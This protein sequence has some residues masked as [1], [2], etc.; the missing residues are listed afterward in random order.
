M[1]EEKLTSEEVLKRLDL[2]LEQEGNL[3]VFDNVKAEVGAR[4]IAGYAI[5]Y[6]LLRVA[7]AI[8]KENA[9]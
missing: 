3:R 2:T 6:G 5:L 7:E 9:Q 8:E 4:I 1:A